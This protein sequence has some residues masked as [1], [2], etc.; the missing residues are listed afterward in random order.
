[1]TEWRLPE[2]GEGVYEAELVS[3]RVKPGQAIKRGQYLME[4]MTDKATMEVPSPF[5]GTIGDLKAESGQQLKVGQVVL[6]YSG[7]DQVRPEAEPVSAAERKPDAATRRRGPPGVPAAKD[8]KAARVADND[9]AREAPPS[10]PPAPLAASP[11]TDA[12]VA[13]APLPAKAAPSV[14]LMA[15]KLG[16]DLTQV[17]GTGPGGRILIEDLTA[18][19]TTAVPAA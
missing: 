12:G 16:I 8:R 4:V 2:L 3:W 18:R 10:P 14:R 17:R 11:R 15:R 7:V 19:L 1:M 9:Q 13:T 6:T 5:A